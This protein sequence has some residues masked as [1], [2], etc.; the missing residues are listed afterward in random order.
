M[1]ICD[2]F[3][4]HMQTLDNGVSKQCWIWTKSTQLEQVAWTKKALILRNSSRP[5]GKK[6]KGSPNQIVRASCMAGIDCLSEEVEIMYISV[7]CHVMPWCH[8]SAQHE[9]SHSIFFQK[10]NDDSYAFP[11]CQRK[12]SNKEEHLAA[13]LSSLSSGRRASIESIT[14][15]AQSEML[16]GLFRAW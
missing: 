2:F 12:E 11:I 6:E 14:S 3:G 4:K 13:A 15:A 5:T 1:W 16:S 7:L 8:P 10:C 9:Q